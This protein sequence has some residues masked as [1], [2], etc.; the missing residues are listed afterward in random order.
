LKE[1]SKELLFVGLVFLAGCARQVPAP[2]HI[3]KPP[4]SRP[5]LFIDWSPIVFFDWDDDRLNE[6]ARKRV[7]E[8]ARREGIPPPP[9]RHFEV[10]G[11][12][13]ASGSPSYNLRLGKRRAESVARELERLGCPPDKIKITSYGARFLLVQ[14]A[15]GKPE[16]QNRRVELLLIDD[17]WR[18]HAK[19]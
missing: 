13:D 19:P 14:T 18:S 1:R 15:N 17:G 8:I 2:V 11:Y 7:D 16:S 9:G 6:R 4:P 5:T 12:T 10:N 3:S